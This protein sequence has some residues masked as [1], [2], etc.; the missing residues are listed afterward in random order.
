MKIG[1][2]AKL[3]ELERVKA[4]GFDY[5]EASNVELGTMTQ[6]A[7][8]AA[9]RRVRESGLPVLR[10]NCLF[11]GEIHLLTDGMD[12]MAAW[13]Q[14]T[15]DRAR[16]LGAEVM[17]FGAGRSR[18]RPEGMP[19]AVALRRLI[20]VARLAGDCAAANGLRIAMEPLNAGETN[21]LTSVA[22]TAAFTAAADHP[23]VGLLADYYHIAVGAE[24]VDDLRRLIPLWHVHVAAQAGRRWPVEPEEGLVRFL[25]ALRET[26]YDATL[27]VEAN[28]DD[29]EADA[30]RTLALLRSL[31]A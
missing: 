10:C 16:Q 28:S 23:A 11:P 25:G 3:E 20:R 30:P 13:L 7:F 2:C 21:M 18:M 31:L 29:W 4:L 8:E 22:E 17:V 9:L 27:S 12:R 1:L 14:Q 19:Y 24:P 5:L 15:F 26:G 6:E